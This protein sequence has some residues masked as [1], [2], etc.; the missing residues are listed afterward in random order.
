MLEASTCPA[1]IF[2]PLLRAA[3]VS[4]SSSSISSSLALLLMTFLSV[5]PVLL[6][7]SSPSISFTGLK[8]GPNPDSGVV[9]IIA[10]EVEVDGEAVST[11][12]VEGTNDDDGGDTTVTGVVGHEVGPDKDERLLVVRGSETML[13]DRCCRENLLLNDKLAIPFAVVAVVVVVTAGE[14]FLP[15][16]A[17]AEVLRRCRGRNNIVDEKGDEED[18]DC[19]DAFPLVPVVVALVVAAVVSGAAV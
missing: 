12:A 16:C 13:L 4:S 11:R 6:H 14:I 19:D 3:P 2:S 9:T 8:F 15:G 1:I 18:D 17:L 7:A 10:F 5:E